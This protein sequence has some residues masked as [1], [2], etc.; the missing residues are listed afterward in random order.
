LEESLANER[1]LVLS[2]CVLACADQFLKEQQATKNAVELYVSQHTF[3]APDCPDAKGEDIEYIGGP[4]LSVGGTHY[5]SRRH[6]SLK[7]PAAG[8]TLFIRRSRQRMHV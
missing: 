6:R 1:L 4:L 5:R 7:Q 2:L 3:S 8:L